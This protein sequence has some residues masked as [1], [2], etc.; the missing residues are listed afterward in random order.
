MRAAT[1][2]SHGLRAVNNRRLMAKLVV[3]PT[4]RMS[5][6]SAVSP[7][8]RAQELIALRFQEPLEYQPV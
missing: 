7:S 2:T 3:V 4:I 5:R 1:I 8:A 6:H